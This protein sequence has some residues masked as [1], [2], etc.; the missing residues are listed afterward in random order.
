[1]KKKHQENFHFDKE[2]KFLIWDDGVK[3]QKQRTSFLAF[4]NHRTIIVGYSS[5]TNAWN[6]V[7]HLAQIILEYNVVLS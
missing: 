2:K 1:M 6:V 4:S 3:R 5:I 7:A